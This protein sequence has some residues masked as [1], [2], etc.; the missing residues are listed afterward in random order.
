M[1]RSGRMSAYAIR[2]QVLVL[3]ALRSRAS[4]S[5]TKLK[6]NMPRRWM[7]KSNTPNTG[8]CRR[9]I[10]RTLSCSKKRDKVSWS[11]F[12]QENIRDD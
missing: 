6:R 4:K 11:N 1:I 7:R 2:C 3:S 9:N 5:A 8:L 12:V 10:T